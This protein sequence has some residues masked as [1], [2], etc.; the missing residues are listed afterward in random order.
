MRI[1]DEYPHVQGLVRVT[2]CVYPSNSCCGLGAS[3][4]RL[5]LPAQPVWRGRRHR[6]GAGGREAAD[7]RRRRLDAHPH[8]AHTEHATLQQTPRDAHQHTLDSHAGGHTSCG[9]ADCVHNAWWQLPPAPDAQRTANLFH[10][11]GKFAFHSSGLH[12]TDPP[13]P[14]QTEHAQIHG[15]RVTGTK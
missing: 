1:H 15:H 6:T 2:S 3:A 14:A 11:S 9:R 10:S 4:A 8:P 5:I 12:S 7:R 13:S